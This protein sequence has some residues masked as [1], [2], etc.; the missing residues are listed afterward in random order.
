MN[1]Q[2]RSTNMPGRFQRPISGAELASSQRT[3][4]ARIARAPTPQE[5]RALVEFW[6]IDESRPLISTDDEGD[7]GDFFHQGAWESTRTSSLN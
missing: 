2:T 4:A 3:E 7:W 5:R 6:G 1:E